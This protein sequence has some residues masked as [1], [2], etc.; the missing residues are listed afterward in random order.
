[1]IH[2]APIDGLG[3]F[4]SFMTF[5][6]QPKTTEASSDDLGE[7][8]VSIQHVRDRDHVVVIAMKVT[9][10]TIYKREAA[11]QIHVESAPLLR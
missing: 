6:K 9:G 1:M 10:R 8:A 11:D 3:G 2:D 4:S 7:R 5:Q